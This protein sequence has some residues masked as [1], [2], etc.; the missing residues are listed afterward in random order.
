MTDQKSSGRGELRSFKKSTG[1]E[2][3]SISLTE[4]AKLFPPFS[5]LLTVPKNL[6]GKP[7]EDYNMHE[8]CEAA[9]KEVGFLG[10]LLRMLS[11]KKCQAL[12]PKLHD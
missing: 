2:G 3:N 4:I 10:Q 8:K 6:L 9:E 5:Q 7:S 1:L 11:Y 12:L